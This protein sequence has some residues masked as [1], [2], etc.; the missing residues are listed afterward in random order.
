MERE[1]IASGDRVI[2][3]GENHPS[4]ALAYLAA[5][6][7]GAVC[8][9]LDPQGEIETISNF[10]ENSEAKLAFIDSGQ[11]ERFHRVEERLG[12]KVPAVMWQASG[13]DAV[14]SN[15]F[16]SFD[17]WS[18]TDFPDEYAKRVPASSCDDVAC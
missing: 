7:R 8:V 4:W 16:R 18:V 12:R 9:P 10:F 17:E 6:Y 15:G 14:S 3:M 5:L 11:A 2:V 1:G 13:T